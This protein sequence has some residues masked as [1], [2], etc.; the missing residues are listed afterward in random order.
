M[1]K[2]LSVRDLGMIHRFFITQVALG[3][4]PPDPLEDSVET[5]LKSGDLQRRF[6]CDLIVDPNRDPGTFHTLEPDA[7]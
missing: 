1:A 2:Q 5:R 3:A 6:Q 7:Q 4:K